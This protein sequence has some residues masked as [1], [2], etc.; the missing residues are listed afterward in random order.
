M[1]HRLFMFVIFFGAL[2]L[3]PIG[4]PL[5]YKTG[6]VESQESTDRGFRGASQLSQG[7][8][9]TP[10]PMFRFD[11]N[12]TGRSP[13]DASDNPGRVQWVYNPGLQYLLESSPAIGEDGTIYF[14][15]P[16]NLTHGQNLIALNPD[17][18]KKWNVSLGSLGG[19]ALL[20]GSA[21]DS[22]GIIYCASGKKIFALFPNGT[23]K[24]SFTGGDRFLSSPAIDTNGTIYLGCRDNKLYAIYAN[25]TSY[26]NYTTGDDIA[27]SSPA[28]D[29]NGTIY[30][31]S[32]DNHTYAIFPNGTLKWSVDVGY[33]VLS[34][35]AIDAN[36]T[37][38]IVAREEYKNSH[39][40]AIH[41]N[42]TKKWSIN[43]SDSYGFNPNVAISEDG[44]IYFGTQTA[45]KAFYSNGTEKWSFSDSF[46]SVQPI[47]DSTGLIFVYS[48]LTG[49]VFA[50][51][52]DGTLKWNSTIHPARAWLILASPAI[53]AS[54]NIIIVS[55]N[56][57]VYSLGKI[58]PSTPLNL[59]ATAGDGH[60]FLSWDASADDGGSPITGYRI[61]R[62]ETLL[63]T[64][65]S[66][67][68]NDTTVTNGLNYTYYV[69]A[70]N[71]A[72][73]SNQS[74]S[75]IAS[76]QAKPL[77]TVVGG[78]LVAIVAVIVVYFIKVRQKKPKRS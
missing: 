5:H 40:W 68:H 73:E 77:S 10:C 2:L 16:G 43:L 48:E 42:G 36:G 72:G 11:L 27:Y 19:E 69:T 17:G 31:G 71:I 53:T 45:F 4:L 20:A 70:V 78:F 33:N 46:P 1:V 39:L 64:V 24:W 61:Y 56:G 54:G 59:N 23:V 9:D 51:Y 21:I 76:P 47:I 52:P 30:I 37:I 14:G 25:G 13:I 12:H 49:K 50:F 18:T 6:M 65:T 34:S 3:F 32:L 41:S 60:V 28:I 38:Y 66:L 35:P 57:N 67:S 63:T 44:T 74:N 75:V 29:R 26:W 62:N 15:T 8:G 55:P 22:E 7:L 58:A